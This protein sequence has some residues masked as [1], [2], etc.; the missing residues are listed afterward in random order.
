MR[1]DTMKMFVV[2]DYDRWGFS[3]NV[4]RAESADA[5]KRLVKPQGRSERFDRISAVEI[6]DGTEPSILW[7]YDHSPDSPRDG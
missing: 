1:S 3:I 7:C 6:I 2:T 5:A 4:V